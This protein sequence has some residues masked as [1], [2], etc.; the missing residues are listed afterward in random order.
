VGSTR[1]GFVTPTYADAIQSLAA[2]PATPRRAASS[3]AASPTS[4]DS[5][6]ECITTHSCRTRRVGSTT[7]RTAHCTASHVAYR[8]NGVRAWHP[9]TGADVDRLASSTLVEHATQSSRS[10]L[11]PRAGRHALDKSLRS[12]SRRPGCRSIGVRA[13][14][15]L[16]FVRSAVLLLNFREVRDFHFCSISVAT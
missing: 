1:H 9:I 16:R 3:A 4:S 14:K 11:H 15:N 6:F 2:A 8:T 10:L 12:E 5:T 13:V 7:E